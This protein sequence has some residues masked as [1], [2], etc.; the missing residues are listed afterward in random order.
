M[1]HHGP[2]VG[3]GLGLDSPNEAQQAR[4]VVGHAV[5][6]PAREVKLPNLPDL[7]RPSLRNRVIMF[8]VWGVTEKPSRCG[9]MCTGDVRGPSAAGPN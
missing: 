8:R 2:G 7:M 3:Q 6:R 1:N 9:E 5:V 4:G